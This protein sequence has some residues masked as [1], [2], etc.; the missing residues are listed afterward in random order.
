VGLGK[1]YRTKNGKFYFEIMV[2]NVWTNRRKSWK[3]NEQINI[4]RTGL[5][6]LKKHI[7]WLG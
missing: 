3:S 5:N 1:D 7:S 6:A 4:H 2:G